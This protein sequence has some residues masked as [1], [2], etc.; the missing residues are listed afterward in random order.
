MSTYVN[1]YSDAW[2]GFWGSLSGDP[3]DVIWNVSPELAAEQDFGHF[4]TFFRSNDL[5]LV[6][7]GCGDGTQTQFL[8]QY[9]SHTIGVDVSERAIELARSQTVVGNINY[10]VL[11]I[12]D[13]TACRGFHQTLSDINIYMRGVLL[14]FQPDERV[15]AAKNLRHLIGAKG[16]IYLSE[17]P[18]E[19]K[20]YYAAIIE[21]QGMPPGFARI[22]EHGIKPGGISQEEIAILFPPDQ[23]TTVRQGRHVM[24]TLIPLVEGG[25]G[26]APAFYRVLKNR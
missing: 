2:D 16:Y 18:P 4:H 21:N 9:F 1:H 20:E 25:F 8:G 6:D 13:E 7:V 12:L 11:D 23:V 17:Y 26:Q 19:V 3:Q 5:P 10:Q 22:L 15:I 14:Q 24:N